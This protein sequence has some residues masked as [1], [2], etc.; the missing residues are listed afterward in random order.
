MDLCDSVSSGFTFQCQQCG[1][2]CSSETEG[3]IFMYM[4]DIVKISESL[5]ISKEDFAKRYLSIT[6]CEYTIWDENLEDTIKTKILDVLVLN[7]E[8]NSDCVFLFTK[9]GKK[10]CKVYQTRPGQ[11]DLFPFWSM[12]MTSEENFRRTIKYCKGLQ[13]NLNDDCKFSPGEIKRNIAKEREIERDYF[14]RMRE[15]DF[16]IFR[17][18]PFLHPDTPFLK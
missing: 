4:V 14:I 8:Q 18:Y 11:C 15:V 17:V 2:C 1:K 5:Q 13:K 10:L 9:D 12:N 7:F 3:Y 16:N 6:K